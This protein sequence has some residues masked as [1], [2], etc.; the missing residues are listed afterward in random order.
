M[1]MEASSTGTPVA[2]NAVFTS[3]LTGGPEAFISVWKGTDEAGALFPTEFW[4][5]VVPSSLS[6]PSPAPFRAMGNHLHPSPSHC[7]HSLYQFLNPSWISL[8]STPTAYLSL[9]TFV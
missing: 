5:Y 3:L 7:P 6:S 8:L 2:A 4:K 9:A 1:E